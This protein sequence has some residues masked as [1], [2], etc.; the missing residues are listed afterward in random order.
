MKEF[1]SWP[2]S[3]IYLL[4]DIKI[5]DV[6]GLTCC[7]REEILVSNKQTW[8]DFGPCLSCTKWERVREGIE[9]SLFGT[10]YWSLYVFI[11]THTHLFWK[12]IDSAVV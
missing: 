6:L 11:H 1:I 2:I 8:R 4:V 3:Q 7:E 5:V 9:L 12:D 10:I